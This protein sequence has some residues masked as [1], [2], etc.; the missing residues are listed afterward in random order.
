MDTAL[1]TE[2]MAIAA[3][4]S[5]TCKVLILGPTGAGR[6]AEG[7]QDLGRCRSFTDNRGAFALLVAGKT[8]LWRAIRGANRGGSDP[9]SL[10]PR[11]TV[12]RTCVFDSSVVMLSQ[13][14]QMVS[15]KAVM[16]PKE[17]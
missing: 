8:S 2:A 7:T 9:Q 3:C 10:A 1:Y 6:Q 14:Q 17:S 12:Q 5:K 16:E 15:H 11:T 13:L 4:S